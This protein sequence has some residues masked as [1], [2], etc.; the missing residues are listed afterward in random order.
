MLFQKQKPA[1]QD[2][3][4]GGTKMAVERWKAFLNEVLPDKTEQ[5]EFVRLLRKA[6]TGSPVE[7]LALN[8][9]GRKPARFIIE[10]IL[11]GDRISGN[12]AV[13]DIRKVA[14]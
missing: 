2:Q 1:R 11:S 13:N 7:F 12:L 4:K 10:P 14:R 9:L 6:I 5:A 3:G 8:N